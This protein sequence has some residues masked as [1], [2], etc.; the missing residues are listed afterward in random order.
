MSAALDARRAAAGSVPQSRANNRQKVLKVLLRSLD[1]SMNYAVQL[2]L[3]IHVIRMR[4][5]RLE[6]QPRQLQLGT[7]AHDGDAVVLIEYMQSRQMRGVDVE[8]KLRNGHEYRRLGWNA[9]AEQL[10]QFVVPVNDA[11]HLAGSLDHICVDRNQ[12]ECGLSLAILLGNR[13]SNISK[14]IGLAPQPED[15]HSGSRRNHHSQKGNECGYGAP[16]NNTSFS[17]CPALTYAVDPGHSL[18]P[19]WTRPHS[20]MARDPEACHA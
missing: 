11:A 10:N 15:G 17:K 6:R 8:I 19:L 14:A 5:E 7:G 1:A 16:V 20:A 4:G 3:L 2:A 13:P 12:N 18:I 9:Q